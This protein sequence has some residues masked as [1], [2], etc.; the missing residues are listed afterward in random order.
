MKTIAIIGAGRLG[1]S[2]GY[3]LSQKGYSIM[4][5][6]TRTQHSAEESRKL[7][8]QGSPLTDNAQAAQLARIIILSVP[9]DDI[10]RVVKELDSQELDWKGKFVFHCSGLRPSSLLQH[11]ESKGALTASVHPNQSFPRKLKEANAFRGVYFALEG[12]EQA[13][14]LAEKI[15]RDLGGHSFVIRAEDKP[16]YH[17]ACSV[18][19]NFFV[20]LLDVAV[21]LLQQCGLEQNTGRDIL[22]P[23]VERTLQNVKKLNT[24]GALSGPIVRGD[25]KSVKNHL[26]ALER[27]S[28]YRQMY[29]ILASQALKIAKRRGE[30]SPDRI[31]A[32]EDLLGRE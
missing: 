6:S 4:A 21:S 9:D 27:S 29:V 8:G 16:V 23:L 25:Y 14:A 24:S 7:I 17:A 10:P 11:L 20:A 2:L 18:A 30:I 5:V 3:S 1:A 28:D 32:L 15:V 26:D 19:S 31:K 12:G 22:L 13:R